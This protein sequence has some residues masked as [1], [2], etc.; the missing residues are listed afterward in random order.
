MNIRPVLSRLVPASWSGDDALAVVDFL[1]Q[2]SDAVWLAHGQAMHD[3][4]AR[5]WR[6]ACA[7]PA[8]RNDDPTESIASDDLPF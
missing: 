8:P 4:S 3:A 7:T 2:L 1:E 5:R 6:V